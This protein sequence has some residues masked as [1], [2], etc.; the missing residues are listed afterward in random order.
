[1]VASY[2]VVVC[3]RPIIYQPP[4]LVAP[5]KDANKD[6]PALLRRFQRSK[7]GRATTGLALAAYRPF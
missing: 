6:P 4:A 5:A 7:E 1:M 2:V 3:S